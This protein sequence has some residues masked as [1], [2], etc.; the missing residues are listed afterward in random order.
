MSCL[1]NSLSYFI[2]ETG[3]TIRQKICDYLQTNGKIMDGLDTNYILNMENQN[4]I[5]NM[6][7]TSSWGGA[8]EIQCACNI[9]SLRIIVKDIRTFDKK[10]I[11]FIPINGSMERTIKIEWSGGHY[12]PER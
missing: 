12:E 3:Y 7:N 5:S 8:I 9:W 10:E 11:E 1:F 6:R 4:Y 2:N